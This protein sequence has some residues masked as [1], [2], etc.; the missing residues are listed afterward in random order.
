VLTSDV[1]LT[2]CLNY[3]GF[4]YLLFYWLP[5]TAQLTFGAGVGWTTHSGTWQQLSLGSV[6]MMQPSGTCGKLAHL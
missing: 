5:L 6:T 2:G 4:F 3:Q 1:K